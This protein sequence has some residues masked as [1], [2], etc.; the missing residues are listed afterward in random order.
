MPSTVAS[1]FPQKELDQRCHPPPEMDYFCTL[2]PQAP[3]VIPTCFCLPLNAFYQS[4]SLRTQA[5]KTDQGHTTSH[6]SPPVLVHPILVSGFT[7]PSLPLILGRYPPTTPVP[8]VKLSSTPSRIWGERRDDGTWPLEDR[9][10][11]HKLILFKLFLFF[12][13]VTWFYFYVPSRHVLKSHGATKNYMSLAFCLFMKKQ[14]PNGEQK[15][16]TN[17]V[18]L[19]KFEGKVQFKV[20]N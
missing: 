1:S 12:F 15:W 13:I 6:L 8:D 20:T 2:I 5:R 16:P 9:E 14:G 11:R 7:W 3:A 10:D 18:S 17:I 4:P 19:I